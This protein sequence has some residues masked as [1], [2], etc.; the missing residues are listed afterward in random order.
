MS[1]PE[2]H[3]ILSPAAQNDLID[4]LRYTGER[5]GHEQLLVYRDKL[6]TALLMITSNPQIG[7]MG[8]AL[9]DTYRLYFV[10]S[11][12]II[13]RIRENLIEVIRILHQRMSISRNI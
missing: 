3:L 5:W 4:I 6:N 13:Y 8:A 7:H 9:P 12:V 11:H 10:G 1:S 2:L